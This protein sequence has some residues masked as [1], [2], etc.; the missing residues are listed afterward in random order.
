[1]RRLG[2]FKFKFKFFGRGGKKGVRRT[3]GR[4]IERRK[5]WCVMSGSDDGAVGSFIKGRTLSR[6]RSEREQR[7]RAGEIHDGNYI[8]TVSVA[9]HLAICICMCVCYLLL[10]FP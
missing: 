10:I 9:P 7:K 2:K 5:R 8:I 4:R 1:M 3:K 6:E